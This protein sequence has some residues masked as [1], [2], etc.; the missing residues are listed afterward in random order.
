[1]YRLLRVFLFT[2]TLLFTPGSVLADSAEA[3]EDTNEE[4]N[5][6]TTTEEGDTSPEEET[7][8]SA[9]APSTAPSEAPTPITSPPL[10]DAIEASPA[11]P[12]AG[13]KKGFFVESTDGKFKVKFGGRAQ[14]RLNLDIERGDDGREVAAAFSIPRARIGMKGHLFTK[15]LKYV[16]EIDFGKGNVSAKKVYVDYTLVD[17]WVQ[18]RA[19]HFKKPFSR[20]QLNSSAKQGLLDRAITDK[21]FG[22]G[23][24]IGLMLHNGNKNKLEWAFAML[25]GTGV[26]SSLSGDVTVDP[27]T[28]E[29][30]IDSGKFSNV[31]DLFDPSLVLRVA[32]NHNGIA[33]Y[34]EI[35]R[36]GGDFRFAVGGGAMIDFDA[37]DETSSSVTGEIDAI[38]KVK[39]FSATAALY[40][41]AVQDGDDFSSQTLD[42]LGFH[43][44]A[45]YLAGGKVQPALRY[46]RVMGMGDEPE[47]SQ[48]LGGA[49]SVLFWDHNVKWVTDFAALAEESLAPDDCDFRVRSQMQVSF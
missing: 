11:R 4:T 29:G 15:K 22:A 33:G 25:N 49:V 46:A 3:A 13:W 32:Y 42:Q 19:G 20:Q 45:G 35:D 24:D 6:E 31:P 9:P 43:L 23:Y 8:V 36:K 12:N 40:L 17:E 14:V 7:K 26:K 38:F 47:V 10:K 30:S 41:G 44:Q 16:L 34:D 39:G 2:F 18:I 28:G 27:A 21:A 37:A 48:E 1:M 5:E